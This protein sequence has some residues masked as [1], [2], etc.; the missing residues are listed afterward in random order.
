MARSDDVI[1]VAGHRLST[2]QLEEACLEHPDVAEAA[3]VGLPDK[4][5]GHV[6]IGL[7]V[8]KSGNYLV[9]IVNLARYT[10][11]LSVNNVVVFPTFSGLGFIQNKATFY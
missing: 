8:L 1:N 4:L 5:K 2:G 7:C 6:P 3:V 11:K 10:E 9:L